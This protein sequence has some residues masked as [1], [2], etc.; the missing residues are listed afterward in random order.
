M[1]SPH[2]GEGVSNQEG[3]QEG[4]GTG[5]GSCRIGSTYL[6]ERALQVEKTAWAK[7]KKQERTRGGP[8][9]RPEGSSRRVAMTVGQARLERASRGRLKSSDFIWR[10]KGHF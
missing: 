5:V 8:S 3:L 6:G 2:L 7:D 9:A 1:L 4:G 10:V